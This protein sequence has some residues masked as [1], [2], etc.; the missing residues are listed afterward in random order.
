[1]RRRL[2]VAVGVVAL[3][4]AVY[5]LLI[6]SDA[7]APTLAPVRATS[8]IDTGSSAVGISA[9]GA[10]LSRLPAPKE[11]TLPLLPLSKPPKSGRLA[12]TALQQAR[13]L[14]AAPAK[15]RPYLERSR[16]GES[17][18]DVILNSGIELRFGDA[19][20]AG[21]KW[22]AAAAVLADPSVTALDYVDLRVPSRA[23]VYGS[24]HYLPPPP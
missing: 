4:A 5:L 9:Q 11:S 18:V 8:A 16:Y 20:Q 6:R 19:S 21:K 3:A 24:G 13:V 12:G 15:L 10:V 14:G 7:V 17:G 22:R 2:T 23:A 1:V